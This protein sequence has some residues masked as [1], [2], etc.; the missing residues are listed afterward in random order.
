MMGE[1]AGGGGSGSGS[2]TIDLSLGCKADPPPG[3]KLA[4]APKTYAGTCPALPMTTTQDVTITSSGNARKFWIVVPEDLQPDEK[5]PI[6]FLWHWLGGEA[7]DFFERG[8]VQMA[9]NTQRFLAVIPQAKGDLQ[10]TWPATNLDSA[11]R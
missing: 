3:A 4:A 8:E 2:G 11:A 1:D 5:L 6:I 7:Q 9:V 10:F